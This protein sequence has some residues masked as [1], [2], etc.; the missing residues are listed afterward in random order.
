MNKKLLPHII[1]AMACA[2]V[3][4]LGLTACATGP[5]P[6]LGQ[7]KGDFGYI[8]YH[9]DG[10]YFAITD[11]RGKSK[12]IVIPDSINGKKVTYIAESAFEN[13]GL[14]SVTIPESVISIGYNAFIENQLTSVTIPST[15]TSIGAGAFAY[16]QLASVIIPSGVTYIGPKAFGYNKLTSVIIPVGV[17]SIGYSAFRDNQL[18]SVTIPA[19]VTSIGSGA[20]LDNRLTS[21]TIPAGVTYIGESA[22]LINRLTSVTIPEGVTYIGESA[23]MSNQL[24]SVAIPEGVTYIGENAFSRNVLTS[25]YI[26]ASVTSIGKDAFD[27]ALFN[28]HRSTWQAGTYEYRNYRWYRNGTALVV[29]AILRLGSNAW[30]VSIDGKSPDSF[31]NVDLS[32]ETLANI[33]RR[34]NNW[35]SNFPARI[36]RFFGGGSVYLPPGTH[37]IEVTYFT[38]TSTGISYSTDSMLWEQRYLFEGY[39]YELTAT[40]SGEQIR[41]AITRQ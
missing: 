24:T 3:V 11:Y 39:T 8:D 38:Y 17:T 12:D 16:N 23:F 21:V 28:Y 35:P 14:T 22:F 10:Y 25:I 34:I 20:F 18:T 41:F 2:V 36:T 15:V 30:L 19:G 6:R 27:N 37:T 13:K 4:V 40:P 7:W 32:E 5:K 26:P 31:Y 33:V 1:V 29:P 9:Y